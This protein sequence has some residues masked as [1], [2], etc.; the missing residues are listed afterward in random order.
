MEPVRR[1]TPIFA[2]C[3]DSARAAAHMTH[4]TAVNATAAHCQALIPGLPEA[5]IEGAIYRDR[6][7][8][9]HGRANEA[10][11]SETALVSSAASRARDD[12][13]GRGH[14]GDHGPWLRDGDDRS[15]G[16]GRH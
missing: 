16:Q 14:G 13:R 15:H 7:F 1:T 6:C 10:P 2:G 8:E 12:D 9:C 11:R 3:C 5:P 4:A